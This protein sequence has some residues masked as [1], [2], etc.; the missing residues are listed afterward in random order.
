MGA[1]NHEDLGPLLG[2]PQSYCLWWPWAS[3][4]GEGEDAPHL[5]LG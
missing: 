1:L 3:K 2:A 4:G 5:L